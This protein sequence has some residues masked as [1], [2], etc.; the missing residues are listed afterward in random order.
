LPIPYRAIVTTESGDPYEE[1]RFLIET[2]Q[3]W[4]DERGPWWVTLYW[5]VIGGRSECTGMS[6]RSSAPRGT[7]GFPPNYLPKPGTPL[8][9][10]V[11]RKLPVGGLIEHNR[12][13]VAEMLLPADREGRAQR[14]YAPRGRG[15]TRVTPE[16]LGRVADIYSRAWRANSMTPTKAVAEAEGVS[17]STA[18]KLVARARAEGLLPPT[19]PGRAS[20]VPETNGGSS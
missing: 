15:L 11:L 18:A 16:R 7:Q 14:V 8:T 13:A 1:G 4:P 17:P 19:R 3:G 6:I 12:A 9:A 20:A 2:S 10:S 5:Q